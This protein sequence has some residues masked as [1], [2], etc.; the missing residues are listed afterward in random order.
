MVAL[1][2]AHGLAERA[3]AARGGTWCD[4]RGPSWSI[5]GACPIGLWVPQER[6]MLAGFLCH[7]RVNSVLHFDELLLNIFS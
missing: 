2:S 4:W 7:L 1:L 3:V 6:Y 5:P